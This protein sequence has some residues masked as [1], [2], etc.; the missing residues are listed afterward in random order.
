MKKPTLFFGRFFGGFFPVVFDFGV[1]EVSVV[2][3]LD[4]AGDGAD[5]V[6]IG[7]VD[8]FHALSDAAGGSDFLDADSN[9][10]AVDGHDKELIGVVYDLCADDLAGLGGAVHGEDAGA[11][12]SLHSVFLHGGSLAVTVLAHDE[13][14]GGFVDNVG[15]DHSILSIA[16]LE[17]DGADAARGSRARGGFLLVEADAL[18][19]V[20]DEDDIVVAPGLQRPAEFVAFLD[21]KGDEAVVADIGEGAHGRSLDFRPAVGAGASGDHGEE[22]FGVQVLDADGGGD[23]LLAHDADVVNNRHALG[24]ASRFGDFVRLELVDAAVAGEEEDGVV[25]VDLEQVRRFVI[26]LQRVIDALAAALLLAIGVDGDALDVAVSAD[27]DDGLFFGD[28]IF[29][30]ELAGFSGDDLGSSLI[31]V[32]VSQAD[33]FFSDDGLES[34]RAVQDVHQVLDLEQSFL[35]AVLQ[36]LLVQAGELTELHVENGVRLERRHIELADEGDTSGARVGAVPDDVND[37]IQEAP[38]N[39]VA[40]IEVHVLKGSVEFVAG[41][42]LDDLLAVLE[43]LVQEH[44]ERAGSGSHVGEAEHD[45]AEGGAQAGVLEEVVERLVRVHVA[46]NFDLDA[47][48]ALVRVVL[49]VQDAIELSLLGDGGDGLD[50]GLFV[51]LVRDLGDDDDGLASVSGLDHRLGLHDDGAAACFVGAADALGAHD[52]AVGWEVRPGHDGHDVVQGALGVIQSH[53]GGVTDLGQ[54]VRR[55]VGGHTDGDALGAVTEQV[56]EL[57]GENGGLF[58]GGGVVVD[59]VDRFSVE[60]LQHLHGNR[61]EAA[62][63]VSLGGGAV[64]VHGAKVAL[65]LNQRVAEGPVL[66]H[67]DEGR[68]DD[69][70]AVGVVVATGLAGDLCALDVVAIGREVQLSHGVKD[71][72]LYGLQAV[73][74]VRKC[75]SDDDRHRVV[76]VRPA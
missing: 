51:D 70:V 26:C 16:L 20:G 57:T 74:H 1:L 6:V 65:A 25:G 75:A 14:A 30:G 28:E 56:R 29:F 63:C 45:G 50:E 53:Q 10:L 13:E 40:L 18:P 43:I 31:A 36:I 76:D 48:A 35:V 19:L 33:D 21:V 32:L 22:A 55:Q 41:A 17:H 8:E 64:S 7:E 3:V 66:R 27:G 34:D 68:I 46:A 9:S 73:S 44:E 72:A 23:P 42:S 24:I 11:A 52:D 4:E 15:S 5:L 49:N 37:V 61:G 39:L 12:S 59:P 60:V 54:V 69:L 58:E 67:T 71:S 62:L 2:G 38:G 47:H